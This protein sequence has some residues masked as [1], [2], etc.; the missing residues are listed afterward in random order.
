[1]KFHK[2]L[3]QTSEMKF[4]KTLDQISEMKFQKKHEIRFQKYFFRNQISDITA[5]D[6]PS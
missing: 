4:Q 2:T 3:N 1:M 5:R 6:V